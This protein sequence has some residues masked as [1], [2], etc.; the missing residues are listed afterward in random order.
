MAET[1][2]VALIVLLIFFVIFLF[3]L[4][5]ALYVLKGFAYQK[6]M[7]LLKYNKSWMAWIPYARDYGLA[8][9]AS[10]GE[11]TMKFFNADA[12]SWMFKF[13]FL[14]SYAISVFPM[15]GA[16]AGFLY[17]LFFQGGV[18]RTVYAKLENRTINS[19]T[20]VGFFSTVID[21]IP[22]IKFLKYKYPEEEAAPV[23]MIETAVQ[24]EAP[25]QEEI[26]PQN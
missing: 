26:P 20:C 24:P 19:A 13:W 7:R 9:A 17:K 10:G 12:P 25:V 22:I 8:D 16:L 21:L 23:P 4:A 1:V 18:Y 5:A 15:G 6:A 11:P 14:F 2:A 3:I